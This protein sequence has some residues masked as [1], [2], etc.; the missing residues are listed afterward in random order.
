MAAENED[1]PMIAGNLTE[2][3]AQRAEME[4]HTRAIE[5]IEYALE[6]CYQMMEEMDVT[7]ARTIVLS[8]KI[9]E[10]AAHTAS[11]IEARTAMGGRPSKKMKK[12]AALS[13]ANLAEM[14]SLLDSQHASD[15]RLKHRIIKIVADAN[16]VELHPPTAV[17][18]AAD[19]RPVATYSTMS[20]MFILTPDHEASPVAPVTY[21]SLLHSLK[22][23]IVRHD[24]AAA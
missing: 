21:E 12:T 13:Q 2:I 7:R 5:H 8:K 15:A 19:H 16:G 9:D 18:W 20:A 17:E 10:A 24:E 11:L 14:Q 1:A 22:L 23:T 3:L 6:S 4:V